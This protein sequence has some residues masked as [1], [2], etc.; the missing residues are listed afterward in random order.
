[1]NNTNDFL[2]KERY[3]F[4]AKR[5]KQLKGFY[6]HLTIYIIVNLIFVFIN[7]ENLSDGESYFQ[8]RNFITFSFWGI[9]VLA[10][11]GSVFL[12]GLLFG[13]NWEERKIKAFMEQ[14]SK[15]V[16]RYE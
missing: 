3:K 12:P 15:E 7:I 9:G 6:T 13:K 8:W 11:A 14:E 5:V 1:M 10:H 2:Q 4:A 16:N